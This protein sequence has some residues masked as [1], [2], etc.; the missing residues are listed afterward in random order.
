MYVLILFKVRTRRF[1]L[2]LFTAKET[3]GLSLAIY[4]SLLY[5]YYICVNSTPICY[6][7]EVSLKRIPPHFL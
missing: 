6:F 4:F 5:F 3:V 1:S 2:V 7:L